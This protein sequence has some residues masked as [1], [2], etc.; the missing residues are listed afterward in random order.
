[1]NWLRSIVFAGLAT[2]TLAAQTIHLKT[3]DL[4][5]EANS[6]EYLAHPLK[7]R[8][9]GSSHYLIQFDRPLSARLFA[10][11]RE[12]GIIVTGYL[13]Q[14]TLMAAAPDDFSLAGLPVR[15]VGRLE[16]RDK[17]S[18]LI[19]STV[20]SRRQLQAVVV[21]FHS[22]V[23]MDEARALVREHGLR[24]IENP[25]LSPHHLLVRAGL[26]DISRLASWDEVAYIFPASRELT[27]RVR[28][29]ACAGAIVQQTTVA[30]YAT[31]GTGWPLTS[32][33]GLA[34]GYVFSQLT[35]ELPSVTTQAEML[36]AFNEW[37]KYV[38]LSWAAGTD[39]QAPYTVNILFARGAHGDQYP[40]D[41]PGGVLAHTF[42]PAPPNPEPIAG[43]M[44]L[45]DDERWQIGADIDLYSV[46]LHEAGHA[47]G[48]A[49]TDNPADVMYPY[50]R[51]GK[52]LSTGDIAT[53][54]S[55]YPARD[56]IAAN[57]APSNPP[58]L[59][60]PP[61]AP[62]V[63]TVVSPATTVST[64]TNPKIGVSGAA[65]GGVNPIRVTWTT[66]SGWI[67]T[68]SGSATWNAAIA[69][70]LG[71]NVITIAASDA[72]GHSASQV[73]T[74]T[75]QQQPSPA[76]PTQP[77]SPAVPTPAPAPA[78]PSPP[79]PPP[80]S[81]GDT[82]PPALLITYPASTILSTTSSTVT[83]KG[84]ASDNV[85]VT[86][87]VWAN[88]TGSAGIATGTMTWTAQNIPLLYGNN[89][90]TVKAFD[91]AGNYGWRSVTIVRQ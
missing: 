89:L 3:R 22:D 27:R 63:L 81:P 37:A 19:S 44:H 75:L 70:N 74:V 59:P 6:R 5:P 85:G 52:Q 25:D 35:E 66:D 65:S 56:G 80:N 28:V 91:A 40:F 79:P 87:V 68:A 18:P 1:M 12:R 30:Q 32:S 61:P 10:G 53:V 7:R 43:D 20:H 49:H 17:I 23:N 24:T 36:R 46:V 14:A 58:P 45:N 4:E 48:L 51:M 73:I 82:T 13:P 39:S 64:T 16:G 77:A 9:T 71:S 55:L 11:L 31:V 34:V 62:L 8:S 50:Y 69:L 41:G 78:P 26:G 84:L 54:R 83:L 67:G 38:Q 90:I 88:S 42:Y 76:P 57:Q 29:Y 60:P 33:A 47:L 72:A 15:W 21:E 86:S 2:A